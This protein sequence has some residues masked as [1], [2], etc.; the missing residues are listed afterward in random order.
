V[1]GLEE[2]ENLAGFLDHVSLVMENEAKLGDEAISL[3]TLHGAKG[4]EFDA[5]FLPGWEEEIF[6]NRRAL[7]E[8]GQKSLEEERR[9][10]YVG[11]TRA[12]SRVFISFAANRRVFNQ[13][14][15]SLPSRF[16]SELPKENM[17]I[18][19]EAGLYGSRAATA[20]GLSEDWE[21]PATWS[22]AFASHRRPPA[23]E[24][25]WEVAQRQRSGGFA[26]GDRVFHDKFGYG[27]V[28][29]VDDAK[30]E[31]VFEKSGTKR[32]LDSFVTRA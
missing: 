8:G 13:W 4:L 31:I 21:A 9:L 18:H 23:I 6:P 5:V 32:V 27:T 28:A 17:H 22:G 11:I 2:W 19:S 20:D 14:Q 16:V 24:A 26:V 12:R 15:S 7:D 30:L 25:K 1:S 29:A 10:A 3:M